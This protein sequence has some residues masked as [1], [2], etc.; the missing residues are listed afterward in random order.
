MVVRIWRVAVEGCAVVVQRQFLCLL[1]GAWVRCSWGA[2]W[3]GAC[4]MN[5]PRCCKQATL[6][7]QDLRSPHTG[8]VVLNTHIAITDRGVR[9]CQSRKRPK[10]LPDKQDSCPRLA[11]HSGQ[12]RRSSSSCTA[13]L[14]LDTSQRLMRHRAPLLQKVPPPGSLCI[15]QLGI[16]P[17]QPRHHRPTRP[18]ANHPSIHLP[19]GGLAACKGK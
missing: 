19:H 7:L 3:A 10:R 4:R 11:H 2:T 14:S 18:S 12:S 5:R 9:C 1:S 6:I 15:A 13:N 17:L 16:Q 8:D